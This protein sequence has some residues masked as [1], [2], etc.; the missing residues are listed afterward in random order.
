MYLENAPFHKPAVALKYS[1]FVNYGFRYQQIA[2]EKI[3]TSQ[4]IT[5]I[6]ET[7]LKSL[8]HGSPQNKKAVCKSVFTQKRAVCIEPDKIVLPLNCSDKENFATLLTGIDKVIV[9]RASEEWLTET[10]FLIEQEFL[11]SKSQLID[12]LTLLYNETAFNEFLSGLSPARPFYIVLAESLASARSAKQACIH[13]AR[14]G[15]LLEDFNQHSFPLFH[16]G[17][18][19]FACI[20]FDRDR[21]F[22]K[23]FCQALTA[24]FRTNGQT[25]LHI[26][27]SGFS[28]VRHKSRSV[29]K[30]AQTVMD[31]AWD[32]LHKSSRR[33]P[34]GFCDY[35]LFVN[36]EIFPIRR[37]GKSTRAKLA[38][39]LKDCDAFSMAVIKPDFKP[40]QQFDEVVCPYL[41]EEDYI[42]DNDSYVVIRKNK[43]AAAT[44]QW[45]KSLETKIIR[46]HDEHLGFSAGVGWYPFLGFRKSEIVTN[47]A[48]ALLHASFYGPG[49]T[50]VFDSLSLH[51]SGD[52]YFG[53]GDLATAVSEYNKGL[54]ISNNDVDLLNS[55]GVAYGLMNRT[56]DALLTFDRV[57]ELDSGNFMAWYNKGLGELSSGNDA[58]AVASFS[59]ALKHTDNKDPDE[60][61]VIEDIEFQLGACLFRQE[62]FAQSV[63]I[64]EKWYRSTQHDRGAQRCCRYIGVSY[65]YLKDFKNS[66]TWLQRALNANQSDAEALSLLG[67]IYLQTGEGDD[68]ALKFCEKSIEIEPDN[69]HFR[70]RYARAL[71]S[72]ARCEEA[73]DVLSACF[74]IPSIRAAAWLEAARNFYRNK[75]LKEGERYAAKV[76]DSSAAESALKKQAKLLIKHGAAHR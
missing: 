41:A 18:A 30:N 16:L 61:A 45:V 68:I 9:E 39:R 75:N 8:V 48:K 46:E 2:L 3:P 5:Y 33:G 58:G 11:K 66:S 54:A 50:V 34:Y 20:I 6:D 42:V 13:V 37:I 26:G 43:S 72:C 60:T 17:N 53:E 47:C 32:A 51:V 21:E 73:F 10:Q 29:S 38:Y 64:L 65:Y 76:I 62:E 28:K 63:K 4:G 70:L 69:Y 56:K 52:A 71:S 7:E 31:E 14:T 57:L 24:F 22:L 36:S 40:W 1:D 67:E 49:S 25:R 74:R 15:R 44:Q 55:L 27:F 35:E 23:S 19:I 59:K 12:Q